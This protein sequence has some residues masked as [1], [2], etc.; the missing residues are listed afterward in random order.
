[1]RRGVA[2]AAHD[3]QARDGQP[4][5][6]PD[7]VHDALARVVEAHQHDAVL[8]RVVDDLLD[9]AGER[10]IGDDAVAR[11]RR[12]V[13]VGDAEGQ[14]RPRHLGVARLDL[15]EALE[16]AFVDVVPVDPQQREAVLGLEDLVLCPDLV[17]QR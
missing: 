13:V 3:Q 4:L 1:M 9:H 12:H 6:R 2:V 15:V 7:H 14:V 17:E 11:M 8:G 16:R 5:L 10:G